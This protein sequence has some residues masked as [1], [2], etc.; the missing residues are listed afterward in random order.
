MGVSQLPR[1]MNLPTGYRNWHAF[2]LLL[3][4][5]LLFAQPAGAQGRAGVAPANLNHLVDNAQIIARGNVV[6]ALLEPHPQ[7]ANLRTVVVT[8]AVAKTC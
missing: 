7:F 1:G 3:A 8:F 2:G 6:S 4:L 5:V